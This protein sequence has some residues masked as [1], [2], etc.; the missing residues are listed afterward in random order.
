MRSEPE[1]RSGSVRTAWPPAFSTAATISGS[2][3]ATT[4]GPSP[5][6]TARAQTRTIMGT[7]PI[8][9]SGLLGSRVEAMRA[10][11]SRM[12]FMAVPSAQPL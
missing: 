6:A 4:T 8:S 9:A 12:G 3:A 5:A 1:G 7:P 2:P 10:G 11:I